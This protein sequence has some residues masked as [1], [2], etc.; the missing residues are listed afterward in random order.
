MPGSTLLVERIYE[1]V[2]FEHQDWLG[3]ERMLTDDA[4]NT[5]GLYLSLPFGDGFTDEGTDLDLYHLAGMD[6]DYK[7]GWT[8]RNSGSIRAPADAG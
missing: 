5:A 1:D 8:T 6:H 7:S 2:V 4:G 3:S